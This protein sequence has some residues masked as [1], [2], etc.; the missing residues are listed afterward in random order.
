MGFSTVSRGKMTIQKLCRIS[1]SF[2]TVTGNTF[3]PSNSDRLICCCF[4]NDRQTRF[5]D[6]CVATEQWMEDHLNMA[7]LGL[8]TCQRTLCE[9]SNVVD[10]HN[11]GMKR[12]S[13]PKGG[14]QKSADLVG[15]SVCQP[16]TSVHHP[17]DV[18]TCSSCCSSAT[19]G[20]AAVQET[21]NQD[22][23]VFSGFI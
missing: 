23:P 22:S 19:C 14:A 5:L 7:Q 1:A 3:G 6:C 12:V 17:S 2:C 15:L 8:A 20:A 13:S 10:K 9:N 4:P 11:T 16:R 18:L 21:T